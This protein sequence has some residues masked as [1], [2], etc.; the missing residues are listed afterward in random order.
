MKYFSDETRARMSES[1]K[2]RCASP[3]WIAKQKA[4]GTN[5]DYKT[6]KSM[7]DSGY[8]QAERSKKEIYRKKKKR[9]NMADYV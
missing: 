9:V 3:E 6:V 7:Y 1:A 4:M 2:R 5:L 8:T